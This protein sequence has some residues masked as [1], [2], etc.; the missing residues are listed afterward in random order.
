MKNYVPKKCLKV[1]RSSAGLGLFTD[2]S[3]KKGEFL[4][5]YTG[6]IL[7][8][9]EKEKKGGKY[10]FETSANRFIDGTDRTNIARYINHS[11]KPNCE[12]DIRRGRVLIFAKRSIKKGDELHFDYGE[13]YV[14]QYIKPHGCR[15][16]VCK[17]RMKGKAVC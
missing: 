5:E 9:K 6:K 16:H 11:C 8:L 7:T 13:E 3:L 14:N 15:C 1:R 17:E 4:I 10:L 2:E 12:V